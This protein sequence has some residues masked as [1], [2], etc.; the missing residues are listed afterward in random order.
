M[1]KEKKLSDE[2]VAFKIDME[3][4]GSCIQD[5]LSSDRIKNPKL[6]KLWDEAKE[7][8]DAITELLEPYLGQN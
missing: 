6:A 4:I 3:G 1:P 8:L 7:K 2:D 5:Y